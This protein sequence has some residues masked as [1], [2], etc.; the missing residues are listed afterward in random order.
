MQ[1]GKVKKIINVVANV[2]I[3][4]FVIFAI[5]ITVLAVSAASNKK[6]IPTIGNRCYLKVATNSMN[7]PKPDALP[8]GT[9]LGGKPGGFA[10]GDLIIGEYVSENYERIFKLEKGDVI[11][12]EMEVEQGGDKVTILNSHRIVDIAYAE[13]G[14]VSY[15]VTQGDNHVT[16]PGTENVYASQIVAV[17][18]GNKIVWVG[19]FIDFVVSPTGFMLLIVL[20]MAA[21]F[22]WELVAFIRAFLKVKNEGKKV[23]TAE[24]E[25]DIKKRAIEEYLR[26][27]GGSSENGDKPETE[28]APE[29]GDKPEAE[30]APENDKKDE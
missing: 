24:D 4:L 22:I 17:Y 1:K 6:K 30:N 26:L 7:A 28:N 14:A 3:W 15:F 27:H 19:G 10:A 21:L 8:D 11:T 5:L 2:I 13:N 25:E 9:S 29:N 16:S 18:T 12:F 23:I 20:P